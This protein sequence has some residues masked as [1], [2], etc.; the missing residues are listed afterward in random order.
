MCTGLGRQTR[1]T[2]TRDV[3][4]GRRSPCS[5]PRGPPTGK[6]GHQHQSWQM[7]HQQGQAQSEPR[8]C[9]REPRS[10]QQPAAQAVT[11]TQSHSH[12]EHQTRCL[13]QV[14]GLASAARLHHTTASCMHASSTAPHHGFMHA[15]L[16]DCTTPQLH[17]CTPCAAQRGATASHQAEPTWACQRFKRSAQ[18]AP[19]LLERA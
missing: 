19:Q 14:A 2:G 1:F 3:Y 8:P 6:C 16:V 5:E 17:A 11:V 10:Y 12:T 7:Q 18:H 13:I 4:W 15:R 9:W